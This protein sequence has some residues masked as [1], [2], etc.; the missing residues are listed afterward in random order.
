MYFPPVNVPQSVLDE[1]WQANEE[2]LIPYTA[3]LDGR[4]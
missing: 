1:I 4:A 2:S 3:V